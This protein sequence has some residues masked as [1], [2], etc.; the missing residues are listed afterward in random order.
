MSNLSKIFS[1]AKVAI[2][3]KSGFDMSHLNSGTLTTGTLV[4]ALCEPLLP[5]DKVSLGALAEINFAPFATQPYGKIDFC[6]EAFFVPYRTIWGGW[7]NFITMPANNPFGT[8]EVRPDK[9]PSLSFTNATTQAIT[10]PTDKFGRGSLADYLGLM[11]SAHQIRAQGTITVNALPFLAYHKIY[12]DWYRNSTIQKP[13]FSKKVNETG[14]PSTMPWTPDA[15]SFGAAFTNN[16]YAWQNALLQDG[17][18]L[19]DLRQRNW[20]KDY[21]TTSAYYPQ[22]SGDILG[23]TVVANVDADAGEGKFSIGQLRQANV[24]Q[25]WLERNNL[26]GARYV[27]QIRGTYGVTPSDA[28]L[29]RPIFLGSSRTPIYTKGVATTSETADASKNNNPFAGQVGSKAGSALGVS[30]SSL[31]GEFEAKEHGFLMVLV[32][33][34]PHANYSSGMR[35]YLFESQVGDIPNPLLQG[36]GE[37][38]VYQ[39]ELKVGKTVDMKKTF[40]Y[41]PQYSHYKYHC[42]EVHGELVD[43]G[44][45]SSFMV[46]RSFDAAPE[47]GSQFLQ[48]SKNALDQIT[49]VD[50]NVSKMIAWYNIG[51]EFKKIST[52]SEYTIPTLGDEHNTHIESVPNRGIQL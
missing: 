17:V 16:G 46:Q 45:L 8:D 12:D 29:Q 43:G 25:K 39:G 18:T 41:Q 28:A 22:A 32:S 34:V 38:A 42:D 40:G 47:L 52:L 1:D 13:V 35:R 3:N 26:C 37:Q 7:Q 23:S 21:F 27:E 5:G 6:M 11:G 44:T 49:S 2:P 48:I 50:A 19:F 15:K 30:S 33:V 20:G 36:L 24:L 31:C 4:P 10:T 14:T 9:L 51:F